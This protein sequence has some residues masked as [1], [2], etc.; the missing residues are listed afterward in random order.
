M[1]RI[2]RVMI[3]MSR[4]CKSKQPYGIRSEK[5]D[6][7]W[8]FTWAFRIKE[9]AARR[10][11]FDKNTISGTI[12]ISDTYP[13]CQ[14]CGASGFVHCAKCGKVSCWNGDSSF[15]C[16]WCASKGN[17]HQTTEFNNIKAGQD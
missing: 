1:K 2:D 5:M 7:G 4:C 3:I 8:V 13:G 16:P 15:I 9:D 14:H 11:S 6:S 10:E 17:I 12:S